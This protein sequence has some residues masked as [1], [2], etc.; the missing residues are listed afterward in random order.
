[1]PFTV[2][3]RHNLIVSESPL[4]LSSTV[5]EKY[6]DPTFSALYVAS[7]FVKGSPSCL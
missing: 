7:L 4:T 1:M 3:S 2:L 5:T 6:H